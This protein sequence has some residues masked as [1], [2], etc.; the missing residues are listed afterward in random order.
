VAVEVSTPITVSADDF[1]RTL[2]GWLDT[3]QTCP[4]MS[5]PVG[6]KQRSARSKPPEPSYTAKTKP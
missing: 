1:T 2:D 5:Q 4:P 6:L 3:N